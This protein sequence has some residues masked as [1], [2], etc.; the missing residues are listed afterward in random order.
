MTEEI[1][2]T[3]VFDTLN[4]SLALPIIGNTGKVHIPDMGK[5]H[6]LK[7][8]EWSFNG[9][10][11][12]DEFNLQVNDS[13]TNASLINSSLVNFDQTLNITSDPNHK[14]FSTITI[15]DTLNYSPTQFNYLRLFY[16][17]LGDDFNDHLRKDSIRRS[18]DKYCSNFF[19]TT[20]VEPH[21]MKQVTL[22]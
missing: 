15:S 17:P 16:D 2:G 12:G 8:A 19:S 6:L 7:A 9:Q 21:V 11:S 10:S 4:L 5:T 13:E 20:Q 1:I 3:N 14:L 22:N 18:S